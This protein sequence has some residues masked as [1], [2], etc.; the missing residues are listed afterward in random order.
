MPRKPLLFASAL[1]FS[2]CLCAQLSATA[3]GKQDMTNFFKT[4]TYFVLTADEQ[5]N[6]EVMAGLKLYW[7]HTPYD[8]ISE[9]NMAK[10]VS[11]PAHSFMMIIKIEVVTKK[12]DQY[13]KVLSTTTDYY[14]YF[15]IINGGK[16]AI[17]H[18]VYQDM[19]A[20]CPINY[21]MDEKPMYLCGYRGQSMVY[22]LH[23]A[24]Q[25]V[26]DKQIKGNSYKMVKQLQ[27]IYNANAGKIKHKILLVNRDHLKDITE[28]EFKAA[29]PY[30]VEFCDKAKFDK[31][32]K[33]KDKSYVIFQP[34]VTVNKSIFVFDAETSECLYFGDDMVHLK[35]KKS[36]IKDLAKAISSN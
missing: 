32:Y 10:H 27:D 13:G 15:G 2:S 4:K 16:K 34:T 7:K 6:K 18:F 8:T 22:N 25:L 5:M 29:Y 28:E 23:Q 12:T 17:E 31:V 35:M 26:K 24:I 20:Y 21:Y 3:Y 33:D 19:V 36:D 14:H 1:L 9:A 30:K 11:D